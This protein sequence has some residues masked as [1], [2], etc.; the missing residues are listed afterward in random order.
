MPATA[1]SGRSSWTRSTRAGAMAATCTTRWSRGSSRAALRACGSGPSRRRAPSASTCARDGPTGACRPTARGASNWKTGARPGSGPGFLF[2]RFRLPLAGELLPGAADGE[3][4]DHVVEVRAD[5][6]VLAR[7][8]LALRL[9]ID[10]GAQLLGGHTGLVGGTRLGHHPFQHL[11][12][13][14]HVLAVAHEG[15]V[16]GHHHLVGRRL[17]PLQ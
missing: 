17:D 2:D 4:A 12:H 11:A 3:V 8:P 7:D 13:F 15:S 5:H 1:T 6:R 9:E 10:P 14:G 16:A